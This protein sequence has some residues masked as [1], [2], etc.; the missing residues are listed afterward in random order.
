MRPL[1]WLMQVFTLH[2]IE[3]R[4]TINEE[5]RLMLRKVTVAIFLGALNFYTLYYKIRYIYGGI[6]LSVKASDTVQMIYDYCQYIVDI[7]FVNKYGRQI[8]LEYVKQYE[9]IDRILDITH[10][11]EIHQR[12][13]RLVII[14]G[15]IWLIATV[16]EFFGWYLSFG[17]WVPTVYGV[18]YLFLFIKMLTLLDMTAHVV[19]VKHRLQVMTDFLQS[20]YNSA[21]SLSTTTTCLNDLLNDTLCNKN[22]FYCN[23]YIRTQKIQQRSYQLKILS[24]NRQQEV[25]LLSRCYLMLTEQ[26]NFINNM[27]GVRVRYKTNE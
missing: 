27:Y 14:F 22:W 11:S 23:D 19:Q 16:L 7:Y 25:K 3:R 21:N 6:N 24:S 15:L 18:S 10:L 1:Q 20:Y 17:W 26:C 13:V 4:N 8:N 5:R 9:C 12:I 2:C